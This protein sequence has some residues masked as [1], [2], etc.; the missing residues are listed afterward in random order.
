VNSDRARRENNNPENSGG[1]VA[2]YRLEVNRERVDRAAS[3]LQGLLSLAFRPFLALRTRRCAFF[4]T[5]DI[6]ELMALRT[7]A[8]LRDG[9]PF[10]NT[11]KHRRRN[12]II[13]K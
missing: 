5:A 10:S 6:K 11:A 4:F 3:Q 2:R 9:R 1:F 12:P 7:P 8:A 13:L